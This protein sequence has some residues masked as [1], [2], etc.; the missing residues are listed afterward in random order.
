[1]ND[2]SE[3]EQLWYMGEIEREVFEHSFLRSLEER[4]G[5]KLGEG[6]TCYVHTHQFSWALYGPSVTFRD[7]SRQELD[8]RTQKQNRHEGW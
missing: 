3:H 5:L 8:V 7:M 1:M 2:V 4:D 6:S